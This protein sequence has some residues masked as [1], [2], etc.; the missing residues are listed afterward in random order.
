MLFKN[1]LILVVLFLCI[2]FT[3]NTQSYSW[4]AKT[5]YAGTPRWGAT[6]FSI[7]NQGFICG[8]FDGINNSEVWAFD[9]TNSAWSQKSNLPMAV[10]TASSFV[11]NGKAYIVGGINNAG[12]SNSLH[13]YDPI[14]NTWVLKAPFPGAARYG[15]AGFSIA[16]LGYF[17]MGNSGTATGPYDADFYEYDPASNAWTQKASFPGVPRYGL[18][19]IGAGNK[20]YA[21]FGSAEYANG[22]AI[23]FNDWW[24]YDPQ[25]NT[26]SAKASLPAAGRSYPSGFEINNK[27]YVGTGSTSYTTATDNFFEFDPILNAWFLKAP[28]MGGPTWL[29]AYFSINGKGYFGTGNSPSNPSSGFYEYSF[30]SI[31]GINCLIQKP[32]TKAG[33]DAIVLSGMPNTN[34]QPNAEFIAIAW[35]CSSLPCTDRSFIQFDLGQIPPGAQIVSAQL[36]LY[37]HPNP[38]TASPPMQ[39]TAN[40]CL[41]QRVLSSWDENTITWNN[42]PATTPVNQVSLAQ[43]L[44]AYQNHTNIDVKW[45]VIDMMANGNYGFMLRLANET[46]YN[47][48][49]FASSDHPD[50]N[51]HPSLEVCYFLTTNENIIPQQRDL[52]VYPNPSAGTLV[53][54]FDAQKQE[55]IY[56]QFFDLYGRSVFTRYGEAQVGSNRLKLTIPEQAN[57]IYFL[58]TIINGVT[59]KK[60]VS[61]VK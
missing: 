33:K 5:N 39:G 15:G 24:E 25:S 60:A 58:H 46:P 49:I 56:I 35:T 7:G 14:T 19:G 36:N 57:G 38:A 27:I 54:E 22:T 23:W 52:A 20:G 30:D 28:Y 18:L 61:I 1:A 9:P 43:S 11:I 48:K 4:K 12:L 51:Y 40:E 16:G 50:P 59:F 21:G 10:R 13:E 17:G 34:T 42:Q 29:A 3:G 2:P 41:I 37:A 31:P 55:S 45:M 6:G 32:A 53:L 26:W 44:S 47:G 8:G